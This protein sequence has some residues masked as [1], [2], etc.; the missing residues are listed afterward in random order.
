V[1]Y[2]ADD[3]NERI[4]PTPGAMARCP[5]CKAPVRARCGQVNV[6][7][8]AHLQGGDCDTWAEPETEWHRAYKLIV[9]RERREVSRGRH[10][11]DMVNRYGAVLELQHSTLSVD[12]IA[13]RERHYGSQMRW[14][15]DARTAYWK[16]RITL[17]HKQTDE[18]G[19]YV[20]FR[21]K[22]ARR[23]I[24]SCT[25]PVF[26]DLGQG[27]ILR[28]KKTY[29]GPPFH[30]WGYLHRTADLWNW[31]LT[32][33]PPTANL[34]Q[35][36]DGETMK[37]WISTYAKALATHCALSDKEV[38]AVLRESLIPP[39]GTITADMLY[40]LLHLRAEGSAV[41][42]LAAQIGD[43]E[44]VDARPLGIGI[45]EFEC[46]ACEARVQRDGY[47]QSKPGLC[48]LDCGYC[49]TGVLVRLSHK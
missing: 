13:A 39:D 40:A 27:L 20:T 11:A 1:L 8:W 35:T 29:P 4:E 12:D 10:R 41:P 46:P 38:T 19:N 9:P 48:T 37:S 18:G 25:R 21:W 36:P 16:E 14:L 32:G 23:S 3:K 49:G 31:L 30:G 22:H 7:H 15:F 34:T 28:V 42:G 26:L 43:V 47:S 44:P 6:W 5:L 17:R 45:L 24:T 33:S 2:A